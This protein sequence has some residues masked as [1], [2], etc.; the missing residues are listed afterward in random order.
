MV[1]WLDGTHINE[2]DSAYF[3]R[4]KKRKKEQNYSRPAPIV[5]C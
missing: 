1:T 4:E 3:Q 2:F 5:K